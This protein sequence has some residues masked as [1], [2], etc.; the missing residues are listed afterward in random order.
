MCCNAQVD[1][2]TDLI[3]HIAMPGTVLDLEFRAYARVTVEGLEVLSKALIVG[4]Q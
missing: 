1:C 2:S 4:L 3:D